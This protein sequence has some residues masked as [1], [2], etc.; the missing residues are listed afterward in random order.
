MVHSFLPFPY[1]ISHPLDYGQKN[2]FPFKVIIK[3]PNTEKEIVKD[4]I[5]C[6]QVTE[7]CIELGAEYYPGDIILWSNSRNM[8]N[9]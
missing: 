9:R 3:N 2:R 4:L 1:E 8:E 5:D 6:F 7:P